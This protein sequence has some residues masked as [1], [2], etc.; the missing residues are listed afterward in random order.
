[1]MAEEAAAQK[2]E[3]EKAARM[4]RELI[5]FMAENDAILE[6]RRL[7]AIKEREEDIERM[8][9]FTEM[10]EA[11]ARKR[12]EAAERRKARLNARVAVRTHAA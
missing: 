10:E 2:A 3:E 1:M 7:A 8:R 9:L 11:E 6:E 5:S 4:K 12:Q